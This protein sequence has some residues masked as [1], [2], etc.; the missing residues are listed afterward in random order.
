[1]CYQYLFLD[2]VWY[3]NDKMI[4]N[5]ENVK[6][7]LLDKDKKTSLTIKEATFEDAAT[8]ICKATSDIGLAITKAKLQVK[9]NKLFLKNYFIYNYD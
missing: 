1:M 2:I 9:G 4:L 5:T 8:Y 3:K 6:V 7:K